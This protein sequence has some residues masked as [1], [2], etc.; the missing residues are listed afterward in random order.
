[1]I[2]DISLT[3]TDHMITF[4]VVGVITDCLYDH[5]RHHDVWFT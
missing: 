2:F 3:D 5:C 1:M 4:K